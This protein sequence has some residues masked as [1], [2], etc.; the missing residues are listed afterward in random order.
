D[1]DS[2]AGPQARLDVP[3]DLL[4]AASRSREYVNFADGAGF[5]QNARGL[6]VPKR[7]EAGFGRLKPFFASHFHRTAP[8][9]HDAGTE[10]RSDRITARP[11][12]VQRRTFDE[13]KLSSAIRTGPAEAPATRRNGASSAPARSGASGG[14]ARPGSRSPRGRS[15]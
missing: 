6:H 2:E 1:P 5:G 11:G 8:R 4:R 9:E 10:V 13:A 15:R 14:A 3:D 12:A 7:N